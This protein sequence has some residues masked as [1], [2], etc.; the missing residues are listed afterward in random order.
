M[1]SNKFCHENDRK[2]S[3]S[4]IEHQDK[5]NNPIN[6]GMGIKALCFL[7][8]NPNLSTSVNFN[9]HQPTSRTSIKTTNL[10]NFN[11]LQPT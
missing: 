5:A 10:T 2:I 4:D 6:M 1:V 7:L 8:I 11:P 9:P 3:I